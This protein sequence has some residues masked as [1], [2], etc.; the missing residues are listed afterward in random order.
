M[1]PFAV[2]TNWRQ[3]EVSVWQSECPTGSSKS[4]SSDS[5]GEVVSISL[6]CSWSISLASAQFISVVSWYRHGDELDSVTELSLN[7]LCS[8]NCTLFTR[9]IASEC[10]VRNFKNKS[11]EMCQT[12]KRSESFLS[13][14]YRPKIISQNIFVVKVSYCISIN[15]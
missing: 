4:T 13:A 9:C 3:I 2:I 11:S 15:N 6:P 5:S 7:G 10:Y 1:T 12:E 8:I 14:I